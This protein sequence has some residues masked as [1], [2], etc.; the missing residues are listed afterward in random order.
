[1]EMPKILVEWKSSSSLAIAMSAFLLPFGHAQGSVKKCL[2]LME[3]RNNIG[4]WSRQSLFDVKG[5]EGLA[6]EKQAYV[7]SMIIPQY[8]GSVKQVKPEDVASG[9]QVGCEYVEMSLDGN[10]TKVPITASGPNFVRLVF[11]AGSHGGREVSSL[12]IRQL[13]RDRYET[14]EVNSYY[15]SACRASSEIVSAEV[16]TTVIFSDNNA[17]SEQPMSLHLQ[18]EI[19][20]AVTHP[21]PSSCDSTNTSSARTSAK[22][23]DQ[24][25]GDAR[26]ENQASAASAR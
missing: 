21:A 18:Q 4:R 10:E 22:S 13:G 11:P 16:V 24:E 2:N 17:I 9:N 19:L 8:Q 26:V 3:F 15:N 12:E 7:L 20:N 6:P 5:L 1:M 25:G 14:H 23:I